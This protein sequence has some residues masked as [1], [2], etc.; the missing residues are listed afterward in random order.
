MEKM[1]EV[2]FGYTAIARTAYDKNIY[3][4]LVVCYRSGPGCRC[5]RAPMTLHRSRSGASQIKGLTVIHPLKEEKVPHGY[6][7]LKP[8][9][10]EGIG[11]DGED[12]FL[13]CAKDLSGYCRNLAVPPEAAV[14][15]D[16]KYILPLVRA[17]AWPHGSPG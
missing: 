11:M 13:C 1:N 7:C 2:P 12:A 15:N 10:N 9:L 6:T 3:S 16:P 17:A 14:P 4:P 5:A 8:N